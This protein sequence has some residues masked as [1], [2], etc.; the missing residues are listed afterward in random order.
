MRNLKRALSLGLTA[1]MISGLM[2]MGTSAASSSYTDVADTDNV[3]AIEVLKAVGI[4]VGDDNGDF[5]PDENVSRNEMAVV[6]SNLMEY[7]VATYAD[8]SPFTDVPDWA[9]PYVA[10]CYTN[11][12]T[13]GYDATT[14]GG[15]DDVTTAQAALMVMKA[16]GY[17]QYESDFGSDWQLET[18]SQGNDISLFDGVESGVQEA[19]TRNDVAQLVLNAL[20]SGT[21]RAST[22]GSISVGDITIV[23]D[24][25]YNYVTSNEDYAQAISDL[26]ASSSTSSTEG[27]IV[28]LGERLYQGDLEKE[29][30][31]DDFMRPATMWTYESGE[32]GTFSDEADASWTTQ[33]SYRDLYNTA[34]SAAYNNYTWYVYRNGEDVDDMVGVDGSD[35]LDNNRTSTDRWNNTGYGVLTEVYVD[36]TER[37]VVVSLVDTF[38][39]EVT[40]VDDNGDGEYTVNISYKSARPS[41]SETEFITEQEIEDD[42]IVLVTIGQGEIQSMAVAETVE[43]TVD[44]VRDNSYLRID[45]TTYYYNRAYCVDDLYNST[46]GLTN[47]DDGEPFVNPTTDNDV[48]IYLDAYG[49]AVAIEGADDTI[50]D[51]LYVTGI[52]QA[53]GDYSVKVVFGDGTQETID[54]DEV[55]GNDAEAEDNDNR[56]SE[57][58]A[59]DNNLIVGRVYKWSQSGNA[60][61]LESSEGEGD[62]TEVIW[63]QDDETGYGEGEIERDRARITGGTDVNGESTTAIADDDT[64]YIHYE[65]DRMWTGYTEV[66]SMNGIYGAAVKDDGVVTVMFIEDS[67]GSSAEDDDFVYISDTEATE[68]TEDGDTLYEY[69]GSYVNADGSLEE[70]TFIASSDLG[71][72]YESLYQVTSR[73]SSDYATDVELLVNIETGEA[74]NDDVF[75]NYATRAQ[76]G[77]L[78]LEGDSYDIAD[79][80]SDGDYSVNSDTFYMVVELK[81]DNDDTDDV[82]QGDIGDIETDEDGRTAVFVLTVDDDGDET[83]LAEMVLVI[84]PDEDSSSSGGGSSSSSNDTDDVSNGD[85]T[86]T[87]EIDD[88]ELTAESVRI[89]STG[90]LS[91]T[92]GVDTDAEQITYD[93]AVYIDGTRVD[94]GSDVLADVIDGEVDG[95]VSDLAYDEGDEVEIIISDVKVVDETEEPEE[96][97]YTLTLSGSGLTADG[98]AVYEG[99]VRVTGSEML[100]GTEYEITEGAVV[101]ITG[102][103]V[104]DGTYVVDG[105]TITAT[106]DRLTFTMSGDFTLDSVPGSDAA[107]YTVTIGEGITLTDA[108][109]NEIESGDSVA[110]GTVLTVDS[111]TDRYLVKNSSETGYAGT[112]YVNDTVTMTVNDSLRVY[113]AVEV[114]L[115]TGVEASYIGT[116]GNEA[117]INSSSKYVAVGTELTLTVDSTN[118]SAVIEGTG[119][120]ATEALGTTYTVGESDVTLTAAWTVVLGEGVTASIDSTTRTAGTYYVANSTGITSITA[121]SGGTDVVEL[122]SRGYADN[123]TVPSTITADVTLAVATKVTFDGDE[124]ASFTYMI[125]GETSTSISVGDDNVTLYFVEGTVLNVVGDATGTAGENITVNSSDV[126][127]GVA[128]TTYEGATG[129]FT[130][131]DTAITVSQ[132]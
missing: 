127:N 3:E 75:D 123:D 87:V 71:I 39:A 118:G 44:A 89:S 63:A 130:V 31:T 61:D 76:G 64:V 9:E 24:V 67:L 107:V 11:G 73:D 128:S 14:F 115:G 94:R 50:E 97:T 106:S 81:G 40:S 125:D 102:V 62:F 103:T 120:V 22:S 51:Y 18:I 85:A 53:Y 26:R 92:F 119:S 12:I 83:P 117:N 72:E 86:L 65:D 56:G 105:V 80:A 100:S 95:T 69:E 28:E 111:T 91:Y 2:V 108:N 114:T 122:N 132:G 41:G 34:G 112:S 116:T 52:D 60:Y 20:E 6:M 74:E 13:S 55:D 42:S 1:A 30:S 7:N 79:T 131:G 93:W 46:A 58:D 21:V 84:V 68:F 17:F 121:A 77:L 37:E 88:I 29:D 82:Y 43:G 38:V 70:G 36:S 98:I 59:A 66:S 49:Y 16:L 45:G 47:L 124:I 32:I 57:Y 35:V 109:G 129:S 99:N 5:N 23:N 54:I 96:E 8:T 48:T 90:N 126:E 27:Y 10:A 113:A 4:M 19:M 15:D 78:M 25:D 33:V 104:A 101:T 110:A